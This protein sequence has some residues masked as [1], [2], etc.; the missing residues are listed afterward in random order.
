MMNQEQLC[1]QLGIS[2]PTLAKAKRKLT[3]GLHYRKKGGSIVFTKAGVTMICKVFGV[4]PKATQAPQESQEP[5][6][7]KTAAGPLTA[8]VTGLY[9]QARWRNPRIISGTVDGEPVRIRVRAKELFKP[10]MEIPVKCV[11]KG[12]YE[13]LGRPRRPGVWQ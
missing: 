9:R 11:N 12:L 7:Q 4:D 8:T 3:A 1:E 6:E 5:Q 2:L 13:C 10:G